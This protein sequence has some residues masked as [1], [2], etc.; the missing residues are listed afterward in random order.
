MDMESRIEYISIQLK[1]RSPFVCYSADMAENLMPDEG[2]GVLPQWVLLTYHQCENCLLKPDTHPYCPMCMTLYPF[3]SYLSDVA[4]VDVTRITIK[5]ALLSTQIKLTAQESIPIILPYLAILSEC[6]YWKY[7]RWAYRYFSYSSDYKAW[8]FQA[9]SIALIRE[10]SIGDHFPGREEMI[11][12]VRH[13]LAR[14]KMT[15]DSL[16]KRIT[17]VMKEDAGLNALVSSASLVSLLEI[18]AEDCIREWEKEILSE[19]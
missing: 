19:I 9:L 3:F 6:P 4:S 11:E 7:N 12:K 14:L 8:V 15:V 17:G 5:E 13:R 2:A 18:S 1:G 10:L 16:R